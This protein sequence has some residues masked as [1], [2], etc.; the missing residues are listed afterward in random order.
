MSQEITDKANA[1]TVGS[2]TL[3][4]GNQY[5]F[6][7]SSTLAVSKGFETIHRLPETQINIFDV[8][9]SVEVMVLTSVFNQKL[10]ITKN[11]AAD[12]TFS[13]VSTDAY[14]DADNNWF[15][16][17]NGAKRDSFEL[18]ADDFCAAITSQD[19]IISVGKFSTLYTDFA[20]YV[21]SYFGLT[22]G[23]ATA[24]STG[25]N[26]LRDDS[27]TAGAAPTQQIDGSGVA[28]GFATLFSG[29]YNWKFNSGTFNAESLYKIIKGD[30]A[31]DTTNNAGLGKLGGSIK[32]SN[33]NGILRYA[34]DS[35]CFGNRD[36][37]NGTTALDPNFRSNYGLT[38]GFM[39]GD[40]IFIPENGF[41]ITLNL[42]INYSTQLNTYIGN[43]I[44]VSNAATKQGELN[45]SGEAGDTTTADGNRADFHA[46]TVTSKNLL[47]RTVSCPL[48]IRMVDSVSSSSGSSSSGSSSPEPAP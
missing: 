5:A 26:N 28:T 27:A 43:N 41:A 29:A 11:K 42:N 17:T 48:L 44:G 32:L 3:Y 40:L 45:V 34:C 36:A 18:S 39:E 33:I 22:V 38:D 16:D 14:F 13:V 25:V 8:T 19:H 10:G 30:G 6:P 1:T 31:F 47:S 23:T 9:Q 2:L 37:Q 4:N 12:G 24:A 35:N 7:A 20:S 21:A 15:I 46:T